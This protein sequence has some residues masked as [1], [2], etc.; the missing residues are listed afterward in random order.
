M[1]TFKS[2]IMGQ[3]GLIIIAATFANGTAM[4]YRPSSSCSESGET[5]WVKARPHRT[6]SWLGSIVPRQPIVQ[7]VNEILRDKPI[8]HFSTHPD[9]RELSLDYITAASGIAW[10]RHG[11]EHLDGWLYGHLWSENATGQHLAY[12]Y[13][14]L[15]TAFLGHFRKG[16][17]VKARATRISKTR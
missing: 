14:D 3:Y 13:S 16:V 5:P 12:I 7:M 11:Q 4:F 10:G 9:R 1:C 8:A 6:K 2:P 15:R 17:M